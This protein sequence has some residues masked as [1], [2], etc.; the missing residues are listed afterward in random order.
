MNLWRKTYGRVGLTVVLLGAVA[1]AYYQ[2]AHSPAPP[3]TGTPQRPNVLLV[4]WDTVRADRL[5][6][7]GYQT[8]PTPH[9]DRIAADPA[10]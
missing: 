2:L 4:V 9:H 3:P 8:P 1:L 10:R 5:S 7:Y 6:C